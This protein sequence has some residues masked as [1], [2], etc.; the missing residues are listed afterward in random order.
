MKHVLIAEDD[1]DIALL[2]TEAIGERLYIATHVVANGALVPDVLGSCR[3]DLLILDV[4]LPGLSGLDV[5]D[6][7]RND[8]RY[9]GVPI[10]FLTGSPEK[11]ATAFSLTGEHRVMAKPF[12]VDELIAA[13]D[14]MV[15]G[16][17]G[18]TRAEG[19]PI[20]GLTPAVVPAA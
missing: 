17:R 14:D 1:P 4:E 6:L 20:G 11:A 10:L 2:L 8:P 9:Q 15:D 5:F 16:D 19:L 12:D 3:P 18:E 7:I 13:V